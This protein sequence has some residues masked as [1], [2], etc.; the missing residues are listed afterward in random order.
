M[1]K[2]LVVG[3]LCTD[4]Y[5]YGE[6]KRLS[7]EAPVPVINPTREV[8]NA[9]MAGNVHN[10][11]LSLARNSEVLHWSQNE[12][13]TKTRYVH[14]KSNQMLLRCD[15]GES[16]PVGSLGFLSPEMLET[17]RESDLV[18]ISDYNKGYL[19]DEIIR[20]ISEE[21]K[22]TLLDTKKKL[23]YST[24]EHVTFTK[25]NEIEYQNNV[26]LVKEFPEK[27][28]VTLGSK[29]AKYKDEIYSSKNPQETIDVSGA[30]DSF[31]AAFGLMYL[32]TSDI[33]KSIDFAND[34]CAN[35]VNKKGV[36][37]PDVEF[38]S[39]FLGL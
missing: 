38:S 25:L 11:I 20:K 13:I 24:I 26:D 2:I 29:G 34:V 36:S 21:S 1:A 9:G 37:L 3:E 5:I 6:V 31:I 10:N 14:E 8:R 39:H 35:V 28:V 32:K 17:I 7:P 30:G 23:T 19:T 15:I 27:F 22:L 16:K 12:Q 18:I 33:E 4:V